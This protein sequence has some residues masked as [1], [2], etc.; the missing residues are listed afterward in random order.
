[1]LSRTQERGQSLILKRVNLGTN[2]L[3]ARKRSP[4][5]ATILLLLRKPRYLLE[6]INHYGIGRLILDRV[7]S[8][9]RIFSITSTTLL[10]TKIV[11]DPIE[12]L[13]RRQL[14][15]KITKDS[16]FRNL[17]SLDTGYAML[18]PATF[19]GVEKILPIAQ[20]IYQEFLQNHPTGRRSQSSSSNLLTSSPQSGAGLE[21]TDLRAHPEFQRL[22][23]YRPFL[24]IA[25][26]Y[27][28]EF[29]ILASIDLQV[30]SA[31]RL[32]QNNL[33]EPRGAEEFHIDGGGSGGKC[34]KCF[35]ALED[36]DE[37]NGA[38]IVLNRTSSRKLARE[39]GYR[40]GR[41][42]DEVI[43]REPWKQQLIHMSMPAGGV[44]FLDSRKIVHCG[45]RLRKR[46]RITIVL[47]YATKYLAGESELQRHRFEFDRHAAMEEPF[48]RLLFNL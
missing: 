28:G 13:Q 25:C 18:P 30:V 41:I 11:L 7:K 19:E 34:L 3:P 43:F 48:D 5:Q 10:I 37:D 21:R 38:T 32:D 42:P 24:E 12:Y 44:L 45:T 2:R 22:A 14:A 1:M 23:H 8:Y 29:P 47:H 9:P 15:K 6:R 26:D 36:V 39:I 27:L 46:P 31:N 35:I 16:P 17:V 40:Q 4:L 20:S 33:F